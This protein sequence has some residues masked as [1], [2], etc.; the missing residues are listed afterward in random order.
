MQPIQVTQVPASKTAEVSITELK[1][2]Q[3]GV[4]T[5][6]DAPDDDTQR[7]MAMG[8]CAGRTIEVLQVGDPMILK[9]YGTRIGVSARLAGRIR[10][11]VC[12]SDTCQVRKTIPHA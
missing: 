7:L 5:L 10:V 6:V 12:I 1:P 2:R 3:L 8:V 9:V 4:I 11:T